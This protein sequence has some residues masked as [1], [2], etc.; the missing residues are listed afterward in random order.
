MA[1]KPS[2]SSMSL[3]RAWHHSLSHKITLAARAGFAG[4]ELF[5]EDL[6][7]LAKDLPGGDCDANQ[8]EAAHIIRQLCD[9]NNLEIIS[10]QPFMHYEGLRD[11]SKHAERVEE[12]TFWFKLCHIL[13]TDTIGLP[14][15]FLPR[16]EITDDM[17]VI[18]SDMREISDLA[19]EQTPVIKFAYE[20]L[21]WGTYV[22]TWEKCWDIIEH[23]DRPNFG[24]CLDTFNL[25][26]RVYADPASAT[27]K[28]L[29]AATETRASIERLVRTVNVKKMFFIQVVDAERLQ[30][31]LQ[32]GHPYYV[33]G[34]PA[35]MNWSRN[36]RLF[37]GEYD[38]GAYLPVKEVL[39]AVFDRLGF[40]GWVSAELFN[41]VMSMDDPDVP[42]ELANRGIKSWKKMVKEFN[43]NTVAATPKRID[44]PVMAQL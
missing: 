31:P 2:I 6:V 30:A 15:S 16:E 29:N 17:A 3:G 25:C 8:L 41:R 18:V 36:C 10:L 43:L 42:A 39:Q 13:R 19:L 12:M 5:Y 27:G 23:V 28:T 7:Y 9:N 37:Y 11:R 24:F 40:T 20:A 44:S 22:D 26:G 21:A 1:F 33:E 35:R 34:Q 38:Q 4:I 14:S 32:P